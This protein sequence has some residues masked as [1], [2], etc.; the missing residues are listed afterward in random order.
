MSRSFKPYLKLMELDSEV[1]SNAFE[2]IME[3]YMMSKPD[4]SDMKKYMIELKSL[5]LDMFDEDEDVDILRFNHRFHEGFSL[6]NRLYTFY[7]ELESLIDH[8]QYIHFS[9][10]TNANSYKRRDENS[11]KGP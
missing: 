4:F 10:G 1:Q 9:E 3:T 11:E 5:L 7:R 2:M 8:Y 6:L